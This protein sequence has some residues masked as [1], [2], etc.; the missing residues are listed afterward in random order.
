V[1]GSRAS[2]MPARFPICAVI[3][4]ECTNG[5]EALVAYRLLPMV[6]GVKKIKEWMRS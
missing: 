3:Y 2:I 5:L 1:C 6:E 4:L